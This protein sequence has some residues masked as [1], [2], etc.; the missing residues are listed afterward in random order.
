[1]QI[2]LHRYLRLDT[3]VCGG[4]GVER[5]LAKFRPFLL[6]PTCFRHSLIILNLVYKIEILRSVTV[7]IVVC[8]DVARIF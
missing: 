7:K 4:G 8:W 2:L 6:A 1:M 3:S 5:P